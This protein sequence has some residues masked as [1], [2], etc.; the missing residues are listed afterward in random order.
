MLTPF[1]TRLA[2][3]AVISFGL[4]T[5]ALAEDYAKDHIAAARAAI[6]A[7][8]VS[9]GF[10]NILIGLTQQTKAMLVRTNPAISAQIDEVTNAAAIELAAKRP[11]LDRQIQEIWAARFTKPELEEITKFYASPVGQKL[12]KET[13]GLVQMTGVA[14]QVW[15]QKISQELLAKVREEM[16]KRGFNL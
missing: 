10:D 4:S 2:A 5:A 9:D 7:S 3:A 8:H 14:A 11:E 13:N 6:E 15:Q 1:A 12:T 16:R